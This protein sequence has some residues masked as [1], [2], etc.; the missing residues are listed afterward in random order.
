MSADGADTFKKSMTPMESEHIF[1]DRQWQMIPDINGGSYSS[2]GNVLF[3]LGSLSGSGRFVDF[4][5]SYLQIP[6]VLQAN[7]VGAGGGATAGLLANAAENVYALSMKNMPSLFHSL[8]VNLSNC[9]C[10]QNASFSNLDINYRLLTSS[11]LDAEKTLLPSMLFVKDS[12]DGY[13]I[14]SLAG[15]VGTP[16]ESNNAIAGRVFTPS[17]GYG[18]GTFDQ[19]TGRLERMKST[20][21]SPPQFLTVAQAADGTPTYAGQIGKN[22][23]SIPDNQNIYY[24]ILATIPL[25]FLHPFFEKLPVMKSPVVRI[26]LYLNAQCKFTSTLTRQAAVGTVYPWTYAASASVTANGVLP[27]MVSPISTTLQAD[28]TTNVSRGLTPA[29]AATVT[30]TATLGIGKSLNGAVAHPTAQQCRVYICQRV[31]NPQAEEKYFQTFP[32]KLV[33]YEDK[34][35][36]YIIPGVASGASVIQLVNNGLSRLRRLVIYP[37]LT[38][39]SSIGG[40]AVA[41]LDTWQSPFTSSPCTT[42]PKPWINNFNVIVS[43]VN[44]YKE[45]VFYQWTHFLNEVKQMNNLNAG[46]DLNMQAGLISQEDFTNGYGFITVD[47]AHLVETEEADNVSRSVTVQLTNTSSYTIDYY[48]VISFEKQVTVSTQIGSILQ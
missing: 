7:L 31:M 20:S 45:P 18:T 13:D 10:V 19:N 4:A 29:N 26:N 47:L 40:N 5:S 27:F 46:H 2:G 36:P 43:G 48:C 41:A 28:G 8:Q 38:T 1:T 17:D 35:S 25:K 44:V 9:E 3:D 14:Q 21:F 22:Y 11:D 42:A 23:C 39:G 33:L 24:Y 37:K 15:N 30:L 32:T 16:I 12:V 34:T 6:L